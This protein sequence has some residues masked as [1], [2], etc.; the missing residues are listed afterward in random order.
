[1]IQSWKIQSDKNEILNVKLTSN[2]Q[3]LVTLAYCFFHSFA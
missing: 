2:I 1:M 3:N